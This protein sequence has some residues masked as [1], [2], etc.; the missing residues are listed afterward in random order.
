MPSPRIPGPDDW[1]TWTLIEGERLELAQEERPFFEAAAALVAE[2]G[3]LAALLAQAQ[4]AAPE[5]GAEDEAPARDEA[6]LCGL[7]VRIV[8]LTRRLV[9][10]TYEGRGE[11]QLLLDR[12]IFSST[13]AMA[14]LLRGRSDRFEAFVREGLRADRAVWRHLDGNLELRDG[15]ALPLEQ[16]M[17]ERL[18]RSFELAGLSPDDEGD[19]AVP[20]WPSLDGQLEAI[21]EPAAHRMHQLGAD[22]VHGHWNELHTHHLRGAAGGPRALEPKLEWSSAQVQPLTAVAIQASRV[23]AVYSRRLGH[24]VADAFRD[25]FL[26]LAGRAAL[27]DRHHEDF[28]SRASSSRGGAVEDPG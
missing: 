26:D 11:L 19:D 23:M 22:A 1:P 13:A 28:S 8:K 9:A 10:E 16:R 2:F 15:E 20:A 24:E 4:P 17:R 18:A 3:E 25:K 14:Y 27:V 5:D 7:T 6:I 21:G 12:E